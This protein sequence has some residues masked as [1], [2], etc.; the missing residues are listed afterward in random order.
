MDKKK[1]VI[2]VVVSIFFKL[3]LTF[4]TLVTRRML[5][6]YLGND[7]NGLNSL[8]LSIIN[9]ISIAE[10][11]IGSSIIYCMYK[12]V[13]ENDKKKVSALYNL[14][15]KLYKI[16]AIIIVL[17]GIGVLPF[18]NIL[19]KDYNN[20]NTNIYITFIIMLISVVITYLYS[21]KTSLINAYKN[22]YITTTISSI[23]LIIQ[24]VL[25]I[26]TVVITHSFVCYL[27]CRIVAVC[28]Q[29]IITNLISSKKYGDLINTSYKCDEQT[30]KDVRKKV[31]AMFIHKIGGM[32]VNSTDSI[33][34]SS[35]LGIIILGKYSNYTL[36]ITSMINVLSLIFTSLMSVIGH[37]MVNENKQM[38]IKYFNILYDINF[39]LGIIF[40]CGY[41]QVINEVI[42]VL[43]GS[44]LQLGK[45]IIIVITVN[46]YIQFL[47]KSIMVFKDACGAF[48]YDRYKPI[49]EG[50]LN[51]VLSLLFVFYLPDNIKVVGVIIATIITNLLICN[52]VEP[53][54]LFKYGLKTSCKRFLIKNYLLD[55]FFFILL[56][57]IS[58]LKIDIN[59][60]VVSLVVNGS[61]SV[62]ITLIICYMYI[63]INKE[64]REDFFGIFNK[65]KNKKRY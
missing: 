31:M 44:G 65:I 54:V 59:N 42:E 49:I 14:Y 23:G 36:I 34:I 28:I 37:M 5:I 53:Y 12:P 64:R 56:I 33:I 63:I 16:I 47:R 6:K 22:D 50:L 29:W 48:Y 20:A 39:M 13:V 4:L 3:I 61:L 41:Y 11:G 26:I 43:F 57:G 24:N 52:I 25:Q 35:F 51:I 32:L 17:L 7:I 46:Y 2:N 19:A 27:I 60:N 1:G 55:L 18:L 38:S 40:F 8:Y 62:F 9:I 15:D 45:S 10:L 21:S 58:Y 30:K